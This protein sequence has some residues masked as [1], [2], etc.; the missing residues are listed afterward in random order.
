MTEQSAPAPT[1]VPSAL[2]RHLRRPPL[3]RGRPYLRLL[4]LIPGLALLGWG[5]WAYNDVEAGGIVHT[6]RLST[7]P[8]PVGQASEALRLV[9]PGTPDHY[10]KVFLSDGQEIRTKTFKSIPIGN[11]LF[12]QLDESRHVRDFK[13]IEVWDENF[14][15]DSMLD[16]VTLGDL[17]WFAEG[18]TYR[19]DLLGDRFTPEPWALPL[20]AAGGTICLLVLMRFVWDQVV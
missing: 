12:W 18:Q 8:G 9:K 2:P 14:F 13:R 3:A 11:G 17:D 4:W 20:A 1:P 5:L 16:Q 10:L 19:L 6:I 7:K 15:R